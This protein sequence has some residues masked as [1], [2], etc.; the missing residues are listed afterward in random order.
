MTKTC[1]LAEF[2]LLTGCIWSNQEGLK[3]EGEQ[4]ALGTLGR[5]NT[6]LIPP[7]GGEE[8]TRGS[9]HSGKKKKKLETQ[10]PNAMCDP[11]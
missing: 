3:G 11:Q 9:K 2:R 8:R 4:V 7:R 6:N 5:A 1:S 10:Q